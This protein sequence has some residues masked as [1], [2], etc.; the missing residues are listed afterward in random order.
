MLICNASMI[1]KYCCMQGNLYF[2]FIVLTSKKSM[3]QRM[4]IR[5]QH[6]QRCCM[7]FGMTHC[8]S[9]LLMVLWPS[10]LNELKQL[11]WKAA[12]LYLFSSK[13]VF[14]SCVIFVVRRQKCCPRRHEMWP[15]KGLRI[16][17]CNAAH[18]IA[19]CDP[20]RSVKRTPVV[21]HGPRVA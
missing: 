3:W 10:V 11:L 19:M 16:R 12:S 4:R 2:W 14:S 7:S 17:H 8:F 15:A 18:D 9:Y 21:V 6:F 20:Q 13:T 5:Q 1:D